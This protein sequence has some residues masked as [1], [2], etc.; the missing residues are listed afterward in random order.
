MSCRLIGPKTASSNSWPSVTPSSVRGAGQTSAVSTRCWLTASPP[1][2]LGRLDHRVVGLQ[3]LGPLRVR[4]DG[5][6][7]YESRVSPALALFR[8]VLRD[9]HLAAQHLSGH[10]KAAVGELLLAV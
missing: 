2:I 6:I 9:P 3:H 5:F 1:R 8:D 10:R 4:E 7:S